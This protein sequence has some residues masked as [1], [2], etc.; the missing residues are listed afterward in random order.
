MIKKKLEKNKQQAD[1]KFDNTINTFWVDGMKLATRKD[2]LCL[3]SLI[4]SLPGGYK[5]Q[6]RFMSSQ[7]EIE[8]MIDMLSKTLNYYPKKTATKTPKVKK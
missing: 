7:A 4:S 3:V 5:E 8:K 1:L 6:F 2:K